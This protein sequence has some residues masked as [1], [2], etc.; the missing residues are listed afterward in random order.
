LGGGAK[1]Q[2]ID[3]FHQGKRRLTFLSFFNSILIIGSLV[4]ASIGCSPNQSSP[5]PSF[6]EPVIPSNFQTYTDET[7]L[8][9]ISYPQDWEAAPETLGDTNQYVR[10]KIKRI[11]EG[12]PVDQFSIIFQA[13]LPYSEDTYYPAFNLVVEPNVWNSHYE[14]V[15]AE[16]SSLQSMCEDYQELSRIETVIGGREATIMEYL[17]TVPETFFAGHF[18]VM[19]LE[20]N[21]NVWSM[22]CITN[23]ED[24]DSWR[25]DF[26][27]IVRSLRINK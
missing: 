11:D 3:R 27:S 17:A 14:V 25:G 15:K 5:T 4:L 7:Q 12:L 24:F 16:I 20:T 10:E 23:L 21:K 6:I 18:L 22:T 19:C 2:I 1:L 8:F 26:Q 13:G 9:S